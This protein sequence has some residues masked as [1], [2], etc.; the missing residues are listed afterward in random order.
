MFLIDV[1]IA[2]RKRISASEILS[3]SIFA[4]FRLTQFATEQMDSSWDKPELF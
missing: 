4:V 1:R 2:A 3:P